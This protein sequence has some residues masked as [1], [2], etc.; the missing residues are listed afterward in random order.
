VSDIDNQK[1]VYVNGAQLRSAQF[2]CQESIEVLGRG[3]GKTSFIHAY[4]QRRKAIEMPGSKGLFV[5]YTYQ[6]ALTQT[7]PSLIAGLRR[8]GVYQNV[9]YTIGKPDKKLNF[10]DPIEPPKSG[11]ENCMF[12]ITGRV[13]QIISLEVKGAAAG[14]NSDDV[15]GDEVKYFDQEK[16]EREVLGTMR[17]NESLFAHLHCHWSVKLTTSMPTAIDSK[18]IL[19][20]ID[21]AKDPE[22]INGKK[23]QLIESYVYDK[24]NLLTKMSS[25]SIAHQKRIM[26]EVNRIENKIAPLRFGTRYVHEAGSLENLSVLTEKYIR[27]MH[28][29]MDP[30]TFRTEILNYRPLAVDKCFYA[31]LDPEIHTYPHAFNNS[32]LEGLNWDFK[33]AKKQTCLQDLDCIPNKSL[34]ICMDWGAVINACTIGHKWDQD[35][36]HEINPINSMY[37]KWPMG[38][39]DIADMFCEYYSPHYNKDY[40]LHH[41]PKTGWERRPNNKMFPTYAEQ[42]IDRLKKR[43]WNC[44]YVTPKGSELPTQAIRYALWKRILREEEKGL[45]KLRANKLKCKF[46]LNSMLNSEVVE[47]H[48]GISKN[49]NTEKK[50]SGVEPEE[51]PHFADTMDIWL[52]DELRGYYRPKFDYVDL[53]S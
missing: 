6:Q 32:Y 42:F 18:W 45:P 50:D 20:A 7:I 14:I 47:D 31:D 3:T 51:A 17:A 49:K 16:F 25:A 40:Y 1:N 46:T 12:W 29:L 15:S 44:I 53:M 10:K 37:V 28:K 30:H 39:D 4:D 23:L 41:D 11:F 35:N 52:I 33:K 9:H 26:A 24:L 38:I 19:K 5:H 2:D 8:L 43:G 27:R 48:R 13:T 21:E 36:R 22:T 34:H